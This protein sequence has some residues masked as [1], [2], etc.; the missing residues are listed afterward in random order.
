MIKLSSRLMR[1]KFIPGIAAII[2]SFSFAQPIKSSSMRSKWINLALLPF[3]AP[4]SPLSASAHDLMDASRANA[5]VF[6]GAA[7]MLC[8][9]RYAEVITDDD[10]TRLL[11]TKFKSQGRETDRAYVLTSLFI[12]YKQLD[13]TQDKEKVCADWVTEKAREHNIELPH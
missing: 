13:K 2:S 6:A 10:T 9:F 4:L 12:F 7:L 3:L 8:S 5:Y 1:Y 11:N